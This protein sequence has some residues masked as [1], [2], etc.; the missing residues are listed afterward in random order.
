[1]P[2][3]F[4]EQHP[5]SKS[6]ELRAGVIVARHPK[7]FLFGDFY[8]LPEKNVFYVQHDLGGSS[9]R[10]YYGPFK[11][12]PWEVLGVPEMKRHPVESSAEES[13]QDLAC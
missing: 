9:T 12:K 4:E 2:D 10:T 3:L 7:Y 6:Y 1:M 5:G 11:G 8:Y 13:D